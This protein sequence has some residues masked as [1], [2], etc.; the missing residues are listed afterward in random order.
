ME[1]KFALF[2]DADHWRGGVADI[3]PKANFPPPLATSRA[4]DFIDRGWGGGNYMQ[5]QHSQLWQSS[6]NWS[7]VVWPVSSWLF[8]SI[9]SHCFEVISPNCGSLCRGYSLV[10]MQLISPT[11][12][13]SLCKTAHSIWLR[14]LSIALEKELSPWEVKELL[15]DA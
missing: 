3:C 2:S 4:G 7:S 1:R 6:P 11:W 13:F 9:C 5:K 14:I 15:D 10:I 8:W 12:G